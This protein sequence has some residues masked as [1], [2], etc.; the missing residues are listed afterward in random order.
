MPAT[1]Q[2]ANTTNAWGSVEPFNPVW[3]IR[4]GVWYDRWLYERVRTFDSECD[5]WQ[6]AFSGY[7]GGLGYVYKRQKRSGEPGNYAVTSVINPGIQTANQ[8]ENQEYAPRI[9]FKHQPK[10]ADWGRQ[11]CR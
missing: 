3:S 10:F 11:V 8:R 1:A 9:V 4:A 2:W 7:N 5:R 6:F